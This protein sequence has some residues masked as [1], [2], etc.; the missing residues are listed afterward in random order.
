MQSSSWLLLVHKHW[1]N[2][3]N[4]CC[5]VWLFIYKVINVSRNPGW[6]VRWLIL[7]SNLTGWKETA[8][9]IKAL[10]ICMSMGL[11]LQQNV[12]WAGGQKRKYLPSA[13]VALI[14][15]H[16]TQ[17]KEKDRKNSCSFLELGPLS[18]TVLEDQNSSFSSLWTLELA[19][20]IYISDCRPSL[21]QGIFTTSY[22]GPGFPTPWPIM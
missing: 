1:N 8:R 2:L 16:S 10:C 22:P 12:L 3:S 9:D 11:F 5:I 19:Q 20:R 6:W 13:N 14:S 18:F 7:D 15:W 21:Q 17:L 4:P